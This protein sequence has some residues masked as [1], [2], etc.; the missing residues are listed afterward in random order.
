MTAS[1]VAHVLKNVLVTQSAKAIS[2]LLT[3][4]NALTV[5]L[6]LT[7]AQV[8]QFLKPNHLDFFDLKNLVDSLSRGV[9]FVHNIL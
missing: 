2:M 8:V 5:V 7:Y 9:F 1:P 3:L 6:A 4:T